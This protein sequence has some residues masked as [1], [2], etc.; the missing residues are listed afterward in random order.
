MFP[1]SGSKGK[2]SKER[3]RS[4][5]EAALAMD[6]AVK[7]WISV[8]PGIEPSLSVRDIRF[9]DFIHRT[10]IKKQ[11]KEKQVQWLRLT[12]SKGP[13]KI[14]FFPHLRTETDPVSETSCFS[15][16]CF[17][18]PGRWIKSKNPISLKVIHHRQNPIVT[19]LLSGRAASGRATAR[20]GTSLISVHIDP[21]QAE[22]ESDVKVHRFYEENSYKSGVW[23][24]S[25]VVPVLN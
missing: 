20:R 2:R 10:G 8:P 3:A 5:Q 13:N 16:V 1:S 14:G 9:S 18:I 11:T 25:K 17:L 6:A 22:L 4:M 23:Y 7:R 19:T 24:K 21:T 12:L 15:L